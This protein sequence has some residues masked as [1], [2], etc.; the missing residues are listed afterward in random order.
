MDSAAEDGPT[1][2]RGGEL[3][4]IAWKKFLKVAGWHVKFSVLNI[5]C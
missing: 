3:Q 2:D 5:R 1:I 4:E